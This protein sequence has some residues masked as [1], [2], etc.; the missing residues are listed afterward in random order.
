MAGAKKSGGQTE[1]VDDL[2]PEMKNEEVVKKVDRIFE[3]ID[4]GK[5]YNKLR[6]EVTEI[7]KGFVINLGKADQ[8]VGR[9]RI[10][11]HVLPFGITDVEATPVSFKRKGGKKVNLRFAPEKEDE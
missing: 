2:L 3:I 9:V 7:V 10:G 8:E 4:V 6:N 11:D 1:I 5:E